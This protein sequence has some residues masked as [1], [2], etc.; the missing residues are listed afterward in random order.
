MNHFNGQRGSKRSGMPRV[1]RTINVV[2]E[3]EN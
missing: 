3:S 1:R 2:R